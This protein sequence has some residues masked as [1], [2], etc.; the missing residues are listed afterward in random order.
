MFR[1]R[2]GLVMLVATLA[3]VALAIVASDVHVLDGVED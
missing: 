2:D 1:G 3:A